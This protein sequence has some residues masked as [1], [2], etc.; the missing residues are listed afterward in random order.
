MLQ[1]MMLGV[2]QGL[3][4]FLPVSSSGHLVLGRDLLGLPAA[5]TPAFEIVVHLGTL[6]SILVVMRAQ[7]LEVVKAVPCLG[8]P[9]RWAQK[10]ADDRGFRHLVL[11]IP[12]TLPTVL[13]ALL[14]K[15]QIDESFTRPQQAAAMLL[16]TAVILMST[17]FL[18]GRVATPELGLGAA[19]IMGLAQ[20]LAIIPGISRSGTTIAAGLWAKGERDQV[21]AF[22]FLMA[23]P[24]ILGAA[25]LHVGD[26]GAVSIGAGQ[27]VL[28][29][30]TSFATGTV[31]L[32]VLLKMVSHGRLWLFAPYLIL[33]GAGYLG[34]SK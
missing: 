23:I 10:I 22:S 14:F 3:T 30:L 5:E 28:G 12:A 24:A 16:V 17:R 29:F 4:E 26:I 20:C 13:A 31:A 21:G 15:E 11:L 34:F 25:V 1:A 27:L 6:A 8:R 7:V 32:I 18:I 33:A 9:S 19:L 2:L